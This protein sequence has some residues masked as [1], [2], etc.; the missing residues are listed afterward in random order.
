ML[1]DKCSYN[2]NSVVILLDIENLTFGAFAKELEDS[3]RKTL[4]QHE[5]KRQ[6]TVV[7]RI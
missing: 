7:C 1:L 3:E 6:K 4:E 5:K 2:A